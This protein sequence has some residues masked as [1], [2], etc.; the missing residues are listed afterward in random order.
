MRSACGK[1]GAGFTGVK[2]RPRLK[3]SRNVKTLALAL[4]VLLTV[5]V[6]A[7]VAL[8]QPK[9]LAAQLTAKGAKPVI[10][11]VGPNFL[12]R[13]KRIPGAIFAGPG[14][15]TEG[16]ELLRKSVKDLPR[17]RELVIYCGCCPWDKCP[18]IKP[19][20]DVLKGMG[21]TRV[22]AMYS[23][24]NFKTDWTDHGYPVE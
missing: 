15:R 16:L 14:N 6:A 1:L 24:S 21:F 8:I 2:N 20:F 4:C 19:A 5:A 3:Y 13:A 23:A 22:K 18:N 9:D 10:L 7:E 17:D 11:Q 12:Y